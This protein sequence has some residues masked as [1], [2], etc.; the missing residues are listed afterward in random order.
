MSIGVYIPFGVGV[1]VGTWF[2][3][4]RKSDEEGDRLSGC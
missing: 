3:E 4:I 2:I 1:E